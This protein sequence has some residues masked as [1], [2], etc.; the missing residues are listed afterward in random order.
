M[1]IYRF[2]FLL[3]V[4]DLRLTSLSPKLNMST[5]LEEPST[6]IALPM[7]PSSQRYINKKTSLLFIYLINICFKFL[8]VWYIVMFKFYPFVCEKSGFHLNLLFNIWGISSAI[9]CMYV[10][11]YEG[12]CEVELL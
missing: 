2:V 9:L 12:M 4:I 3:K 11:M 8:I 5:L 6:E 7:Y 1:K 10:C